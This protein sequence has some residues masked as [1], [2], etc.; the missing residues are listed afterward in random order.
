VSEKMAR[1]YGVLDE[2]V[3]QAAERS[4]A[5]LEELQRIAGSNIGGRTFSADLQRVRQCDA[6]LRVAHRTA[7][8]FEIEVRAAASLPANVRDELQREC[9]A[10][11]KELR[12]IARSIQIGKERALGAGGHGSPLTPSRI[13]AEAE[14]VQA[15]S[16]TTVK[17]MQQTVAAT[18]EVG[19]ELVGSLATQR[20]QMQRLDRSAG[21]WS[22]QLSAAEGAVADYASGIFSDMV[23]LVLLII[24]I[25]A[26]LFVLMWRLSERPADGRVE[27]HGSAIRW[28]STVFSPISET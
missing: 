1:P 7:R 26:L 2:G 16:F 5:A 13:I 28:P 9:A 17:R 12:Q 10:Q 18:K 4:R 22:E 3:H 25:L 20:A 8:E 24:I 15:E 6:Q 11:R 14:A 23:S 19:I 27:S 21:G